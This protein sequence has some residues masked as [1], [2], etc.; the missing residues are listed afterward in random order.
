MESAIYSSKPKQSLMLIGVILI[1]AL[2][3]SISFGGKSLLTNTFGM[4]DN[5]GSVLFTTRIFYW[6][7]LLLTWLYAFKI[8][9]QRLLLWQERKYKF[10]FYIASVFVLIAIL[11]LG[12]ILISL[13]L[14]LI[15]HHKEQ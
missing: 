11:V 1:L 6:L 7:V 4:T 8:E 13:I 10:W 3:F 2:L 9:K 12:D 15:L 14:Q 5:T